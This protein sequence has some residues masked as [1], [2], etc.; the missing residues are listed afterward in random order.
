MM[1]GSPSAVKR[2]DVA[3]S[4]TSTGIST[5]RHSPLTSNPN[6]SITPLPTNAIIGRSPFLLHS[7]PWRPPSCRPS[8]DDGHPYSPC[9]S[10]PVAVRSLS[11]TGG[12][13]SVSS[14]YPHGLR[15]F[16]HPPSQVWRFY[17]GSVWPDN[18]PAFAAVVPMWIAFVASVGTPND[19]ATVILS[20]AAHVLPSLPKGDTVVLTASSPRR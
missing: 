17:I 9:I 12:I 2:Y 10:S 20:S 15:H 4:P 7:S 8:I 14:G 5:S 13:R 16:C 18:V 19:W 11:C 1:I 3:I 6:L